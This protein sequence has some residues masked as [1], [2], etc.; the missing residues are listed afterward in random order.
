MLALFACALSACAL[1]P[2][3]IAPYD[4]MAPLLEPDTATS[5]YP[6]AMS[7]PEPTPGTQQPLAGVTTASIIAPSSIPPSSIPPST[8]PRATTDELTVGFG[9]RNQIDDRYTCAGANVSPFM[10]WDDVPDGTVETV[11]MMAGDAPMRGPAR[12]HVQWAVAGIDPSVRSIAEGSIP[13]G[14]HVVIPYS[15]VCYPNGMSAYHF[16]VTFLREH[17]EP[18]SPSDIYSY[19][20]SLRTATITTIR[21]SG[22]RN[23]DPRWWV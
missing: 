23:L 1:P 7:A 15:A 6:T 2:Q 12:E 13:D 4:P 19:I 8:V 18:P 22:Y 21:T 5:V 16:T 10:A 14:S 20:G 9:N 17:V 11:V 3:S